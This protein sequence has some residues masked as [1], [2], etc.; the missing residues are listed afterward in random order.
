MGLR[1]PGLGQGRGHPRL[2]PL[3]ALARPAV[4]GAD[5]GPAYD[6]DGAHDPQGPA[7][8]ERAL[9][10]AGRRLRRP[11]PGERHGRQR[12]GRT[13]HRSR[14][15]SR[16]GRAGRAA[17]PGGARP[18]RP[19]PGRVPDLGQ[20]PDRD[21]RAR[22]RGCGRRV[23]VQPDARPRR[24]RD[25][26]ASGRRRARGR[27]RRAARVGD[28][29]QAGVLASGARRPRDRARGALRPQHGQLPR[30][31]REPARRPVR[32]AADP[33]GRSGRR[34]ARGRPQHGVRVPRRDVGRRGGRHPGPGPRRRGGADAPGDPVARR[35]AERGRRDP[36]ARARPPHGGR[37][38][39]RSSCSRPGR[40]VGQDARAGRRGSRGGPR[41]RAPHRR[42]EPVRPGDRCR[43][44]PAAAGFRPACHHGVRAHG[45]RGGPHALRREPSDVRRRGRRGTERLR[46]AAARAS[47]RA[48]PARPGACRRPVRQRKL[49]DRS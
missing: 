21:R 10:A 30:E 25:L 22:G 14:A 5:G 3:P 46:V 26:R 23:R 4:P 18:G 9:R 34:L 7:P 38:P 48:P 32:P 45:A 20:G 35:R 37:E 49:R 41:H 43:D 33:G 36:R 24:R 13:R 12:V 29:A 8:G 44:R 27:A 15:R 31:L 2:G 6:V 40:R 16:R 11:G 19:G 42:R 28:P 1:E 39:R 47:P 17:A